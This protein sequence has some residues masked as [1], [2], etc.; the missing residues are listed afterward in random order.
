MDEGCH[1]KVIDV[2]RTAK[3]KSFLDSF[4][5]FNFRKH[6]TCDQPSKKMIETLQKGFHIEKGPR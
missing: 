3:K 1:I 5:G 6:I 2:K 4:L